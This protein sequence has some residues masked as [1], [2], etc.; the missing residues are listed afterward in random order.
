MAAPRVAVLLPRLSTY[1]G[2]ESFALRLARELAGA[3]FDTSFVCARRETE[4]PEGVRVIETGRPRLGRALKVAGF[5]RAAGRVLERGD[6]D[7]SLGLGKTLRQ[8]VLRASGGPLEVFQ[9]LSSRAW[10]EGAARRLKML[11]RRAS[12]ANLAIRRIERK[13]LADARVVVAVSHLVRDWLVEA[14]PWLA[15][16]DVRVIYNRPDLSRFTPPDEKER[17]DARRALG[18]EPGRVAVGLAGTNFALKGVG[19]LIR[20]M[21]ELPEEFTAYV[22]GGRRPGRFAALAERLGVSGRVRFL[23]RVDDM[24]EFYR[25]LDVF[26]LPSFYDT[27]SNAVLEALASGNRVVSSADNGAS[28]FLPER[29]VTADP[30]DH[31]GLARMIEAAAAEPPPGA[32]SWPED[33]A[34][35]IEP[36]VELVRELVGV[37]R[38]KG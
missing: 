7:V 31:R 24:P 18:V 17:E 15:D 21:A 2:A 20:A 29:R 14:H 35:G 9:R 11:R 22:A 3:G 27:C 38:G 19:T 34:C 30:A 6:F 5:A 12:P 16:K 28:Y 33:V 13:S 37:H 36:Y 10:P 32:F 4:P 26:A 1:G 25:A 23:G 8:D